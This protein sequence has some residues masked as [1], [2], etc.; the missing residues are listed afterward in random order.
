M[1]YGITVCVEEGCTTTEK[2]N[3]LENLTAEIMKAQQYSV[4]KTI[5]VTGMELDL[6]AKH[7]YSG[8]EIIVECKAWEENI[9]ADVI[10]KL[11]GNVVIN[12]ASAGW[13]ITTGGLGKDAEGL[14]VA[15]EDKPYEERKKLTIYTAERIIELLISSRIVVNPELLKANIVNEFH[16]DNKAR[17]FITNI[18]KYWIF[19]GSYATGGIATTVIA[20]EAT[21]GKKVNDYAVLTKL[22]SIKSIFSSY[23]WATDEKET[24]LK[25][26]KVN[27]EFQD[28]VTVMSGD[29]WTDYRPSRPEDYVGRKTLINSIF[30]YFQSVLDEKSSTRLFALKSPSGWGKSSSI[31]KIISDS[32]QK[33]YRDKFYIYA[34]DVRTALSSRYAELAFKTCIEQ[35]I[36]DGFIDYNRKEIEIGDAS[37]ITES[38]DVKNIL[39]AL[40]A[41]RKCIVLIFDQFEEIFYKQELFDL[42]ENMRRISNSVDALKEN[43]I[44]GYAWKTD[45][46]IPSDHPAYY[47]WSNLQDRRKEFDLLQFTESEIKSAVK[48][49]GKELGEEINPVLARYLIKQCQGYPWLLKKLC[50]HIFKIVKSGSRQDDAIN[51]TLNIG[52]LFENEINEFTS[53]EFACVQQIAKDSPADYFRIVESYGQDTLQA[54]INR[55]TI[56]KRS[57]KLTL[58]WDIFKDYVLFGKLPEINVDYIPQ[59]QFATFAKVISVLLSGAK[60]VKVEDLAKDTL[61]GR[62]TIDNILI[63]LAM[64]G[65]IN[66]EKDGIYLKNNNIDEISRTM[67]EFFRKH[68]VCVSLHKQVGTTFDLATYTK[69]FNTIYSVEKI[70]EKTQRIYCLRLLAWLI[71]MK[72]LKEENQIFEFNQKA[73]TMGS[74]IDIDNVQKYTYGLKRGRKFKTGRGQLSTIMDLYW[75]QV[76]PNKVIEFYNLCLGGKNDATELLALGYKKVIEDLISLRA[77][78]VTDKNETV[79]NMSFE[80]LL[81]RVQSMK[82]IA[83]AVN[84]IE[85]NSKIT[86]IELGNLINVEFK[87]KWSEGTVRVTGGMI[88]RWAKNISE[89]V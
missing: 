21:T 87:K 47:L 44:V 36:S 22:K 20:F 74:L 75:P 46:S 3:L 43:L 72:I 17:L 86:L 24:N 66:R 27:D 55:R 2:G 40:K 7:N 23:D 48:I 16:Y 8:E 64:F 38:Q 39:L 70:S 81:I 78:V 10:S 82:N 53:E 1:E 61:L 68:I 88:Y 62:S 45:F 65:I 59:V 14:R 76:S 35:A 63:D 49:F 73:E 33:K 84:E 58:Y 69:I 41:S 29:E 31:I 11:L 13:L 71:S 85:K 51:Q 28:I 89:K 25:L 4:V 52:S 26:K 56:I 19:V 67:R 57:T 54:L 15:W 77:V 83:Y 6:L 80:E 30:G 79:I 60:K 18:G 5:R 9:K 34:V 50:I 32:K 12:N 42:F 37:N